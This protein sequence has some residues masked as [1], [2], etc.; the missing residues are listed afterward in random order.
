MRRIPNGV[1]GNYF[2]LLP[3]YRLSTFK[4]TTYYGRNLF[5]LNLTKLVRRSLFRIRHVH[6]L[7]VYQNLLINWANEYLVLKRVARVL[8]S[9]RLYKY[10]YVWQFSTVY[11][12]G[13]EKSFASFRQ[14]SLTSLTKSTFKPL[15]KFSNSLFSYFQQIPNLFFAFVS[16]YRP[17][18]SDQKLSE[19][20]SY[21]C[22]DRS[23]SSVRDSLGPQQIFT[24]LF[25]VFI[26]SNL[27]SLLELYRIFTLYVYISVYNT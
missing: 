23:L 5:T 27:R 8:F 9:L 10:T 1:S 14:Y 20:V 6:N 25:Q 24:F 16:S 3:S 18:S 26:D 19:G 11:A 13:A 2:S 17:L 7:L 15:F 21:S 22:T 12:S 4:A